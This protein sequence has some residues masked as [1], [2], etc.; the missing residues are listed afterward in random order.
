MRFPFCCDDPIST[1]M[2][3]NLEY[4]FK[5]NGT[6]KVH[7]QSCHG[8][9]ICPK[10]ASKAAFLLLVS[11]LVGWLVGWLVGFYELIFYGSPWIPIIKWCSLMSSFEKYSVNL[12]IYVKPKHTHTHTYTHIHTSAQANTHTSQ[13][14]HSEEQ[15]E[16]IEKPNGLNFSFIKFKA[17]A[18]SERFACF[19]F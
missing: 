10:A 5:T 3:N 6:A 14:T 4:R 7:K 15:K 19:W 11:E 12:W 17:A 16:K 2:R 9:N 13:H 8:K 18:D 1:N